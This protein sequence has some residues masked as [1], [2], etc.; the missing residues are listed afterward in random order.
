MIVVKVLVVCLVN[1][2]GI[3]HLCVEVSEE[4]RLGSINI[5]YEEDNFNYLYNK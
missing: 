3:C 4:G 5:K 2:S 1:Q